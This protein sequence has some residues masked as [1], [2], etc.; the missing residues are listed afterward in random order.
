VTAKENATHHYRIKGCDKMTKATAS[1]WNFVPLDSRRNIRLT[2][3]KRTATLP[4][5]TTDARAGVDPRFI[6]IALAPTSLTE[7]ALPPMALTVTNVIFAAAK[8]RITARSS[9]VLR[10]L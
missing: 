1:K 5:L 8:K 7:H 6:Q 4:L 3:Q 10:K 9:G 2:H